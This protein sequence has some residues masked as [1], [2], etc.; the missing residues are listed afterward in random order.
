VRSIV[1]WITV[2]VVLLLGFVVDGNALVPVALTYSD[3][4]DE[5]QDDMCIWVHPTDP[6]LST[7]I[8]SDKTSGNVYVYDLQGA[9]I[10]AFA[11]GRPGNVDVRYGFPLA[12]GCADLVAFNER[13][14]GAIWVYK[15]DPATRRLERVGE[16]ATGD[17]YGFTL[18]RHHDGRLFGH[19]GPKDATVK[20]YELFDDGNGRIAGNATGWQIGGSTVEGM[21][22][23]D[24]SGYVYVSEEKV[25]VWRVDA[26]DATDKTLIAQVGDASGLTDDV[27]GLAIYYLPGGA[28]YLIVSSQGASK[29]TV[30]QRQ[31]PHLPVGEFQIAGVGD[32]DGIDVLNLPLGPTFAQGIF[33]FHNGQNCCP[34]QAARWSDIVAEVPGLSIDTTYWNPRRANGACGAT[35]TSTLRP[36][37][38]TT[39]V[40]APSTTTPL[41]TTTL[42]LPGTTVLP[43]TTTT[44]LPPTTVLPV[45]TTT[46]LAPTTTLEPD[47]C[48]RPISAAGPTSVSD[49]LAV[50]RAAVGLA[51]CAA[52]V[53]DV[54]GSGS[55]R[56]SDAIMV[57]LLSVGNAVE[58][59]CP[60]C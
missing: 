41:S 5:D 42:S 14:S 55:I 33:T 11:A 27:E 56:A 38:T 13:D 17:N 48:G 59:S 54:D 39:V 26:I 45:T 15:I 36:A 22:G 31:A 19:T 6:A 7:I 9:V 52:C 57:L 30:L 49:A 47:A 23:D 32:T 1:S 50:L 34:I 10:Q 8:G 28:G 53:C 43:I 29:F 18:Y 16:V 46:A 37:T 20:Q 51:S 4:T 35:T 60:S 44:V 2:P 25:G 40:S 58:L 21:S 3:G 12:T 24:E